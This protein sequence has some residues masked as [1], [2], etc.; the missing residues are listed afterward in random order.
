MQNIFS[1]DFFVN[2]RRRLRAQLPRDYPVVLIANGTMQRTADTALV[3]Q[4]ESNFWY[5]T[6]LD[7]PDVI[8]V[9]NSEHE[10]L[11]LPTINKVKMLFDGGIDC[12]KIINRSGI[13]RVFESKEGWETL[14][15][16]VKSYRQLYSLALDAVFDDGSHLFS[17]PAQRYFMT[18][19][20][21]KMPKLTVHDISK[22]LTH[23]R[24]TKQPAELRV[25]ERA[26]KIT[27][28]TLAKL[29]STQ[30]LARFAYEYELEAAITQGFRAR[31]ASG[32]AYAPIVASGTH[33]TTL[34]YVT[35]S[36]ALG[37]DELIVV[38]VGAEYAH[39]AADI[40]RT[41]SKRQPSVRQ[42]AV[43]DEVIAV[44]Q[45]ALSYLEPGVLLR[46][47]ERTVAKL[48][49]KSLYRLKLTTDETDMQ[50]I[51]KYFPH[52]SSHFLG[53]DVHDVG[54][55]EMP[56]EENMVLTCEP[57]IYI[58]EENIGVRIEDDIVITASGNRNLSQDCS[59]SAYVL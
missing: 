15:N 5:L 24:M 49:G 50:A 43:L 10:Y 33:A 51:R 57:G 22:Q 18:K 20:R 42:Q 23:A 11:I 21:K 29:R 47:Y 27:T 26:V 31:A 37:T 30:D 17:N 52:A 13:A 12:D 1:K 59:Y 3:F 41:L 19:F 54:D 40:S 48:M 7:E 46:D 56:L 28:E 44:Q 16:D 55:Y 2:N 45:A 36:G 8:L 14:I 35:N 4:Q 9:M 25:I 39:Y 58:P 38:D 32:H 53:L 6:G 34:H